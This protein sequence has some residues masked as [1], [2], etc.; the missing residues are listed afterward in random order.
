MSN[1]PIRVLVTFPDGRRR[2]C[3]PSCNAADTA[4]GLPAGTVW[5]LAAN[6]NSYRFLHRQYAHLIGIRV[7]PVIPIN[8]D[9]TYS[10]RAKVV[11]AYLPDGTVRRFLSVARATRA[12]GLGC[13]T[14][15]DLIDSGQPYH[16]RRTDRRSRCPQGTTF[17]LADPTP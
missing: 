3:Y 6:G 12:M 9:T 13:H 4:L 15:R 16:P 8:P 17:D 14:I 1:N 10:R 5:R 2:H 7:E 11:L